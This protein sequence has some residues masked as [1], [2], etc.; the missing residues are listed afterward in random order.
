MNYP[1]L[2]FKDTLVPSIGKTGKMMGIYLSKRLRE[3]Q[4]DLTSKQWVLLKI[5][6]TQDGQPQNDLAVITERNKASLVR[7]IHNM[8]RKGLVLRKQDPM[9]KRIN[10]IFLTSKGKITYGKTLPT[11]RSAFLDMQAGISQHEIEVVGA[12]LDRIL[13]NIRKY[14]NSCKSI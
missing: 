11:V 9:D 3:S 10:R 4:I 14:E 5:L 12:I 13:D 7:L 2:D 8:E 6:H 1:E